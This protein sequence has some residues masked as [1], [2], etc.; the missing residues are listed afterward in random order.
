MTMLIKV[1]QDIRQV[2][3]AYHLLKIQGIHQVITVYLLLN[4][5]IGDTI[6]V[7]IETGEVIVLTRVSNPSVGDT[8]TTITMTGAEIHHTVPAL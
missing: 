2:T 1:V 8:N 6:I 7:M 5:L 4:I 3:T